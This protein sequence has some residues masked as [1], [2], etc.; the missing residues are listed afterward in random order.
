L[1]AK[2]PWKRIRWKRGRGT[3]RSINSSG[4]PDGRIP[5]LTPAYAEIKRRRVEAQR[6]PE[7]AE[8]TGLQDQCLA[9]LTAAPPMLRYSYNS[10]YQIVQTKMPSSST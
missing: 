5:A 8:D 7:S 2:T 6:N 10:N 9:F 1:G 4:P 3:R